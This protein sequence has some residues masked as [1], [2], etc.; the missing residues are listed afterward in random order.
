LPALVIAQHLYGDSLRETEII[1]RNDV[2]N[3][4]RVPGGVELEVLSDA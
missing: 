1:D 4:C 3:P 2:R